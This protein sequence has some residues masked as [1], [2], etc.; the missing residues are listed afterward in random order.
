[1]C[2]EDPFLQIQS[3]TGLIIHHASDCNWILHKSDFY[4]RGSSMIMSVDDKSNPLVCTQ[5][6]TNFIMDEHTVYWATKY[7]RH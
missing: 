3:L 4:L 2:V 5:K 1:M 6:I 7:H